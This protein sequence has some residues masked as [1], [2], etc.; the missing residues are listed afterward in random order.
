MEFLLSLIRMWK[1]LFQ[2]ITEINLQTFLKDVKQAKADRKNWGL[3]FYSKRVL[4][5]R[6]NIDENMM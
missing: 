4:H 1:K 2:E 6:D 5:N 3:L